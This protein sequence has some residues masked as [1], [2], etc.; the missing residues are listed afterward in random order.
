[1]SERQNA[2]LKLARGYYRLGK[3]QR[4]HE[5]AERALAIRRRSAD[6][7]EVMALI[8]AALSR[9]RAARVHFKRSVRLQRS[10]SRI[11]NNYG[12]FLYHQGDFAAACQAFKRAVAD[13]D[14]SNREEAVR[15]LEHCRA[16]QSKPP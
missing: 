10:N 7:H 5:V 2:H 3:Y 8:E 11:W 9:P 14:Y 1:M 16:A 6:A 12:V 15:S 4:A 13:P